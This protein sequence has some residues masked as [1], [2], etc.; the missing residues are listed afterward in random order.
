MRGAQGGHRDA[1]TRVSSVVRSMV[2]RSMK[3]GRCR[4][5]DS[6]VNGPARFG[7]PTAAERV[8]VPDGKNRADFEDSPGDVVTVR[9][10]VVHAEVC[11]GQGAVDKRLDVA[12]SVAISDPSLHVSCIGGWAGLRWGPCGRSCR[13][14]GRRPGRW[15][16]GRRVCRWVGRRCGRRQRRGRVCQPVG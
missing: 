6:G 4:I 13:S 15:R 7:V 14:A 2:V 9:G 8:G 5:W 11:C 3:M 16:C 12:A 1:H 10:D